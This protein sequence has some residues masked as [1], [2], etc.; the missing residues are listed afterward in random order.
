MLKQWRSIIAVNSLLL[1]T[2]TGAILLI[3]KQINS[4]KKRKKDCK[5]PD[6]SCLR[7]DNKEY[8]IESSNYFSTFL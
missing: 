3:L 2:L 8:K 7:A 6:G 5:M 1:Y 4:I